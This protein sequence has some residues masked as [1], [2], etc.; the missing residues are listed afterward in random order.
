MVFV[1]AR[2]GHDVVLVHVIPG[3]AFPFSGPSS[4]WDNG[5]ELASMINLQSRILLRRSYLSTGFELSGRF[6][7]SL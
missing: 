1:L 6:S 3:M 5:A 2:G 7:C 4:K